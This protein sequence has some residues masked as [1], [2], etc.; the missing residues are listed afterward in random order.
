MLEK[1]LPVQVLNSFPDSFHGHFRQNDQA[2]FG[3]TRNVVLHITGYLLRQ[4]HRIDEFN[5]VTA[6]IIQLY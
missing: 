4:S 2:G 3:I 6:T 5:L 1:T